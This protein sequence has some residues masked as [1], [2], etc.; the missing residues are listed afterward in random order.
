MKRIGTRIID[1][2]FEV[3]EPGTQQPDPPPPPQNDN[4][5]APPPGNT[6]QQKKGRSGGAREQELKKREDRI[7]YIAR[8]LRW[9]AFGLL[10]VGVIGALIFGVMSKESTPTTSVATRSTTT[11]TPKVLYARSGLE[12]PV[13]LTWGTPVAFLGYMCAFWDSMT[14]GLQWETSKDGVVWGS[15]ENFNYIRFR[16]PV[17]TTVIFTLQERPPSGACERRR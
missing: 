10:A 5:A 13:G 4:G 9:S 12:I 2:D 7:A 17:D 16:S 8:W 14:P 6:G 15:I 3:V 1:V 11:T